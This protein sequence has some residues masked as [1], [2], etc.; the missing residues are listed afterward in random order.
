[1]RWVSSDS[2]HVKLENLCGRDVLSG[3]RNGVQTHG[4]SRGSARE[5]GNASD[6]W[7]VVST[8]ADA[9]MDARDQLV[10]LMNSSPSYASRKSGGSAYRNP[11]RECLRHPGHGTWVRNVHHGH[12]H[13]PVAFRSSSECRLNPMSAGES[14]PCHAFAEIIASPGRSP[15][16]RC[17]HPL[18]KM[19]SRRKISPPCY[20]PQLPTTG[21]ESTC[22]MLSGRDE[23]NE[24][25]NIARACSANANRR[26]LW[27]QQRRHCVG[28]QYATLLTQE[29]LQMQERRL[30]GANCRGGKPAWSWPFTTTLSSS[31]STY[32]RFLRFT[33][34]WPSA[35]LWLTS[36][37]WFSVNLVTRIRNLIRPTSPH[38]TTNRWRRVSGCGRDCHS[39]K[40]GN[41]ISVSSAT[42]PNLVVHVSNN[43]CLLPTS[44]LEKRIKWA[45]LFLWWKR[46][47]L[48]FVFGWA[49][50]CV[51]C[52]W[53]T[54]QTS[55][56]IFQHLHANHAWNCSLESTES[57][58][59][60]RKRRS[61][62]MLRINSQLN[63]PPW[64]SF[65]Y[66]ICSCVLYLL[67]VV[68]LHL[69]FFEVVD[70]K[71]VWVNN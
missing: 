33:Q 16:T 56:P 32:I 59:A 41:H 48:P 55:C 62:R 30:A 3:S 52:C 31:W 20:Q 69:M 58:H 42:A 60:F 8:L 11:T 65:E 51:P 47:R 38:P 21:R 37:H 28:T 18:H 6:V 15:S 10:T 43:R 53:N 61:V 1:M 14:P 44:A 64:L 26:A 34:L 4:G 35:D 9:L 29:T 68:L 7:D 39:M 49:C 5:K 12:T 24:S 66:Y 40:T 17:A 70:V 46:P 57:C 2:R 19:D 67:I 13:G 27:P 54:T 63:F 22:D 71:L 23:D 45:F 25:I 36:L 50:P